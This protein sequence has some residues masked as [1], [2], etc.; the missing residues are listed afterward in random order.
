MSGAITQRV[1]DVMQQLAA[2]G[3]Q[4]TG[5]ADD[6]RQ[7]H[8]GDLFVAYPG[9]FVDGRQFIADAIARGPS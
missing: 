4:P 2:L 7:V 8:S 3:V 5:V 1:S 6:S 9:D